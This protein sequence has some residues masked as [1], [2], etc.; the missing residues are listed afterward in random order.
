M[1]ASRDAALTRT[2]DAGLGAAAQ[3]TLED[4]VR[5]GI[6]RARVRCDC[7]CHRCLPCG[8]SRRPEPTALSDIS[9]ASASRVAGKVILGALESS[10]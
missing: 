4:T 6:A 2:V 7:A 9:D 5:K 1:A 8:S 3:R 10:L